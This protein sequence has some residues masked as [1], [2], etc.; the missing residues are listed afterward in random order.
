M[1]SSSES[2]SEKFIDKS[3][4]VDVFAVGDGAGLTVASEAEVAAFIM[5]VSFILRGLTGGVISKESSSLSS[6]SLSLPGR[7]Y[8]GRAS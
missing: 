8:T 2:E 5:D 1:M 3:F 6:L 4:A 7:V